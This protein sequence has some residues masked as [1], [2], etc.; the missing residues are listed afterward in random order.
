MAPSPSG[1][2][3]HRFAR[4]TAWSVA[5]KVAVVAGTLLLLARFGGGH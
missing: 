3:V 4:F 2:A 1:T 5:W